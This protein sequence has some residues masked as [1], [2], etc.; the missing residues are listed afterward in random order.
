MMRQSDLQAGL[1]AR[2]PRLTLLI[3]AVVV[4]AAVATAFMRIQPD[5]S[6]RSM[7][8]GDQP[9]SRAFVTILDEFQ[10]VNELL[11]RV[12]LPE[13]ERRIATAADSRPRLVAFARRLIDQIE[14]DKEAQ[15]LIAPAPQSLEEAWT[16]FAGEVV[17]P[18]AQ[19]YLDDEAFEALVHRLSRDGIVE[20][21]RKNEAMISAPGGSAGAISRRILRDPLR[22]YEFVVESL[23]PL[24]PDFES[25]RTDVGMLSRDGTALLLLL[26]PAHSSSDMDF[27]KRLVA[28]LDRVVA[29]AQPGELVVEFTGAHVIAA[30]SEQHIRNDMLQSVAASSALLILLLL[31]V[32]RSFWSILYIFVPVI[33]G[34]GAAFGLFSLLSRDLS[35]VAAASA[36]ILTGLGVDYGIHS[37]ARYAQRRRGGMDVVDA[38]LFS[39]GFGRTLLIVCVT[40]IIAFA[41]IGFSVVPAIASFGVLGALGLAAV[42]VATFL[43]FPAIAGVVDGRDL[44]ASCR[45][46]HSRPSR[47]SLF[48]RAVGAQP[49][50]AITVTILILLAGVLT[51]IIGQGPEFRADARQ[52]HPSP[53]RPLDI[54]EQIEQQFATQTPT[55]M[56]LV[57]AKTQAGLLCATHDLRRRLLDS[58]QPTAL[59]TLDLA[60][61]LPDPRVV[62][63]RARR[64]TRIDVDRVIEDLREAIKESLF[65]PDAFHDYMTFLRALL[66]P[67]EA[68]GIDTLRRYP[69]LADLVLPADVDGEAHHHQ[70]LMLAFIEADE[71]RTEDGR[72]WIASMEELQ[73]QIDNVS[74]STLADV[75]FVTAE[76]LRTVRSELRRLLLIAAIV[77]LLWLG[78]MLRSPSLVFLSALPALFGMLMLLAT[79]Q[80]TAMSVN[81]VNLIAFPL[82]AGLGVDDGIFL[83]RHFV[84]RGLEKTREPQS[85]RATLHAITMTSMTTIIAFGSLVFTSTPAIR[86]LGLTVAIGM[87]GCLV[88]ATGLLLPIMIIRS[89][90]DTSWSHP[91]TI[92]SQ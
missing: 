25:D 48:L 33:A 76:V 26:R 82:I 23:R 55:A 1:I 24:P 92:A 4:A 67:G 32:Y 69:G 57:E 20:Q 54:Q 42:L 81:I 53:S 85:P 61:L 28:A 44:R 30:F 3:A 49:R 16:T 11:I 70:T 50:V 22:L 77:V 18:A 41:A 15:K 10:S 75:S 14:S 6:M 27:N 43:V 17:A 29:A 80:V 12:S 36:A 45:T 31:C 63:E 21:I 52:M 58:E 35:P 62:A 71:S 56:I 59:A 90:R 84:S 7:L 79:M 73:T 74:G 72:D 34:I 38:A 47:S 87:S 91:T 9:S 8:A 88:G 60:M 40:S 39:G 46:V 13:M 51:L 65:N 83:V 37:Y 68:P 89:G 64:A 66:T 78:L 2:Y 86:S 5:T 19:Y